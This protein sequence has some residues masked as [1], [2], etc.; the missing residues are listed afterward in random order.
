[1][2]AACKFI[3]DYDVMTRAQIKE[4]MRNLFNKGVRLKEEIEEINKEMTRA[5]RA[6]SS[7]PIDGQ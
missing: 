5:F 2:S 4:H 3:P 1:M 7:R 6:Y